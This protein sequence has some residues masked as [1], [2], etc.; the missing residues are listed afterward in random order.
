MW[1]GCG[2]DVAR[3]WPGCGQDVARVWPGCG[4]DVARVWPGCGQDMTR[5]W[6]VCACA[7]EEA[8]MCSSSTR[9][10]VGKKCNVDSPLLIRIQTKK[11]KAKCTLYSRW[12]M[13]EGVE[14]NSDSPLLTRIIVPESRWQRESAVDLYLLTKALVLFAYDTILRFALFV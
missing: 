14:S 7:Q 12:S 5:M 10:M 3:M 13:E 8:R 11:E 2:Q 6:P 9:N 1:P 4:Q